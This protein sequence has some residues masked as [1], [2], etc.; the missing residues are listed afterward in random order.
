M[1]QLALSAGVSPS[2]AHEVNEWF[3]VGGV[4]AGA[5][6]CQVLT[7]SEVPTFDGSSVAGDN[8]RGAVP[9]QPE[10]ELRFN[11]RNV[12]GLKLGFAAG[13]ALN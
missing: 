8:C 3:S 2:A 7:G 5:V 1:A 9:F 10:F 11:E 6:Q 12:L 4:A 13:N